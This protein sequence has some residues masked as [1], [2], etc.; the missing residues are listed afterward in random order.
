MRTVSEMGRYLEKKANQ[1]SLSIQEVEVVLAHLIQEKLLD[2]NEF[3]KS[4]ISDRNSS[5]QKGINLLRAELRKK[6]IE[7]QDVDDYFNS[8]PQDEVSL[9]RSALQSRT[10]QWNMLDEV[11]R[12]KKKQQFLKNRG[13]YYDVIKT[14]I[15][16]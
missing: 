3:I 7:Q 1:M 2:D 4:F 14:A 9:A 5:K 6:G 13:F 12:S 11:G 16:E 15:E 10:S 8:H